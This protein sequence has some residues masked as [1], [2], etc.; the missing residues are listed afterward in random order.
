MSKEKPEGFAVVEKRTSRGAKDEPEPKNGNG[1]HEPTQ[2]EVAEQAREQFL[3]QHPR[4]QRMAL[5]RAAIRHNGAL[6][7]TVLDRRQPN[8][9][10][11]VLLG[12]VMLNQNA[13][14]E[15]V[16]WLLNELEMTFPAEES[17]EDE[18]QGKEEPS[19]DEGRE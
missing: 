8:P 17:L 4:H 10:N 1:G 13:L 5:L 16:L 2:E 19:D 6:A 11:A 3:G 12:Q 15:G 9:P 14:M 18:P 7:N